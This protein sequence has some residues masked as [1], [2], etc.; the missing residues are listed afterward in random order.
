MFCQRNNALGLNVPTC[1]TI[2]TRLV[3]HPKTPTCRVS[4]MCPQAAKE[5]VPVVAESR[6]SLTSMWTLVLE[7]SLK[8][9]TARRYLADFTIRRA[10]SKHMYITRYFCSYLLYNIACKLSCSTWYGRTLCI[11]KPACQL[12]Y[13]PCVTI[14]A[15]TSV[16]RSCREQSTQC[17]VSQCMYIIYIKRCRHII[18]WSIFANTILCK[19]CKYTQYVRLIV[20]YR[21]DRSRIAASGHCRRWPNFPGRGCS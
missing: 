7:N 19:H 20:P 21:C 2:M 4:C 8:P 9:K 15:L 14:T 3:L 18:T 13:M 5:C 12:L 1:T 17:R 10:P 16:R 6:F 11:C